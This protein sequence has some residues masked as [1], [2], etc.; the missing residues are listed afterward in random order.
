M[1]HHRSIADGNREETMRPE[2][3]RHALTELLESVDVR[4]DGDR[5][6]DIRVRDPRF[7]DRVLS[8]GT[9]GF[10]ES[11]M[12]GWWECEALDQCMERIFRARLDQQARRN[13]ELV[14][15]ALK[16]RLSNRQSR[17]RAFEVGRRHYD[18]G[19]DL[20]RAMLDPWLQYTCA[21][22]QDGD[23][24]AAAQERKLELICRKL[25]LEPGMRVLDLG[26]GWGGFAAY[27]ARHHGV[28]VLG[29][30]V[31]ER[32][33]ELG[34]ELWRDDDV[35]LRLSDYR[36]VEGT[37]DRVV[38]IGL[39]EHVGYKNYRTFFRVVHDRLAP[40]GIALVHT[41]GGN[42][43]M[44]HANPW[45][46]RYIFP[47]GMLPSIAQIGA[48]T[49]NLLV[50]ED[51]H[52]IGPHYDPTLMAWHA[53]FEA[54]WPDLRDRYGE[55]FRRMWRFYLLSC[56]GGFRARNTQLWQL[57]LTRIGRE[58]PDCRVC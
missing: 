12:D 6:W 21:Y 27:A 2:R 4:V 24:L 15:L 9:L 50:I 36:E 31:A 33:V 53:R 8:D 38:A 13:R 43:T 22:W 20:Y 46:D 56:A 14:L 3:Q 18:I 11:Y 52:N 16:A 51:L 40:D 45:I 57:V 32:Q 30:T 35:E 39:L 34:R 54:A 25:K 29:V 44:R 58:Q 1:P 17:R 41:I 48:A 47:N 5:P 23:D 10:G 37:F 26:C 49:E 19:N 28:S 7:F 55:R 42:R